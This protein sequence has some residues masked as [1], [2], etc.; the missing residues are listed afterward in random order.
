LSAARQTVL[1]LT[2]GTSIA[3]GWRSFDSRFS[4]N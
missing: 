2:A 1:E 4:S 3:S